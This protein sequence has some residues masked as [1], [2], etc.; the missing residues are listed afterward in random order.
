VK[1]RGRL[2][3]AGVE[4]RFDPQETFVTVEIELDR[5]EAQVVQMLRDGAKTPG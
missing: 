3:D 5:R 4:L 1:F 2:E